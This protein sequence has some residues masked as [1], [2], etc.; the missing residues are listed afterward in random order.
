M[1]IKKFANFINENKK[2]KI[3]EIIQNLILFY[4]THKKINIKEIN[5][6]YC[7][8]F[9]EDFFKIINSKETDSFHRAY[10]EYLFDYEDLGFSYD[11]QI[12]DDD[13][14]SRWNKKSIQLYGGFPKTL[15]L[16]DYEPDTHV[17]IY[18][19]GYHYD[20]ENPNGV[21]AW[22]KLNFFKR[23]FKSNSL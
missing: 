7:M 20:A 11:E 22:Y 23:D 12:Y 8:D 21:D 18:C 13:E 3:T 9:A 1:E 5:N 2:E 16:S 17:W 19:D 10:S 15:D 4:K 14:L 6:G